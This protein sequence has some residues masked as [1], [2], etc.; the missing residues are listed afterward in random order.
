MQ[1]KKT[2][3]SFFIELFYYRRVPTS[4]IPYEDE[5]KCSEW[6]HKLFQEKVI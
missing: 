2:K 3:K 1:K 5:E 4:D 6:I